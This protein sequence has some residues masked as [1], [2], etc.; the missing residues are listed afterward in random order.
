[1]DN[2]AANAVKLRNTGAT[3]ISIGTK[4]QQGKQLSD[5]IASNY[6]LSFGADTFEQL[7]QVSAEVQKLLCF[8]D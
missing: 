3:I 1:M 7:K 8:D 5:S 4:D 2:A 6:K